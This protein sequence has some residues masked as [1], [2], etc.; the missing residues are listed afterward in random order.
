MDISGT[1]LGTYWQNGMPTRFEATFI[2]GGNSL[3]GNILDDSYLGEAQVSGEVAG[4][5]IRFTK[6]YLTSSPT[7][8]HYSGTIAEDAN[9]M[10]GNWRI[11]GIASGS[12]E[13]HRS[14]TDLLAELKNRLE[15]QVPAAAGSP[16][17]SLS[18]S[19]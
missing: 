5:S 16:S 1:W 13:A 17:S 12:W 14:N 7:P 18:E 9:S 19:L 8:I 3:S 10:Q 2:Q 15:Q 11:R 4:R 6:R